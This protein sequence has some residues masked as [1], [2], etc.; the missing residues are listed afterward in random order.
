[1]PS[2]QFSKSIRDVMPSEAKVFVFLCFTLYQLCKIYSS[3]RRKYRTGTF[4]PS[5]GQ[6]CPWLFVRREGKQP[7]IN[8]N[9]FLPYCFPEVPH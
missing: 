3:V 4:I 2:Y 5:D 8:V 9:S 6:I 1:M 7:L